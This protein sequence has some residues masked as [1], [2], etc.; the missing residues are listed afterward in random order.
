MSKGEKGERV[1]ESVDVI[2]LFSEGIGK[3]ITSKLYTQEVC[4]SII[5]Q[6][7]LYRQMAGMQKRKKITFYCLEL[8]V[9]SI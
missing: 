1:G 8:S 5:D 4:Y 2:S 3:V 9:V 7:V 6:S